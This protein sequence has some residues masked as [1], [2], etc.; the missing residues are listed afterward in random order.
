MR[1]VEPDQEWLVS[2]SGGQRIRMRVISV[3]GPV[4]NLC[5]PTGRLHPMRV[6]VLAR[7]YRAAKLVR[8]ADG[9]EPPLPPTR[10]GQ[11]KSPYRA[12]V[13]LAMS[14]DGFKRHAIAE[15]LGASIPTVDRLL[16]MARK[17]EAGR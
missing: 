9:T 15:R 10:T 17:L 16:A 14:V 3:E 12:Q 4:A 13:A 11:P 5:S 6:I 8:N 2:A 7:G 1:V